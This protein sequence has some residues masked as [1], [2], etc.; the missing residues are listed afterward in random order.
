V[1]RFPLLKGGSKFFHYDG[2][3]GRTPLLSLAKS[4]PAAFRAKRP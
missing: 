3:F 4:Q 1:R 2:R